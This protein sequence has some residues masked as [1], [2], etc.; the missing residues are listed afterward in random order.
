MLIRTSC[1]LRRYLDRVTDAWVGYALPP[2]DDLLADGDWS[3]DLRCAYCPR[4]GGSLGEGELTRSGCATCRRVPALGDG[5]VRLGVY[6]EPL[7]EWILALKYQ[8]WAVMGRVLGCRLGRALLDARLVDPARVMA[9]PVPMP[10]SRR[11]ARGIDHA[12][13]VSDALAGELDA[14]WS[15]SFGSRCDVPR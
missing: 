10:L 8:E 14:P 4:C 13:V 6:R 7:R 15:A 12:L 9:V 1:R 2:A 11:I 5:V 3:P